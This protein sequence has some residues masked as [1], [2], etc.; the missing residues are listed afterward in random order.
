VCEP[1]HVSFAPY[2]ELDVELMFYLKNRHGHVSWERVACGMGL[3]NIY[4]FLRSRDEQ[5]EPVWLNERFK[6]ED[7]AKVI[8]ECALEKKDVLCVQAL[9]LMV[10]YVA[11]HAANIALMFVA[12]G[13]V[14]IGGGIAPKI[15]SK[16]KEPRFLEDFQNKGR[17]TPLLADMPLKVI[18]NPDTALLGA[19]LCGAVLVQKN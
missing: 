13:G 5:P 19:A 14:Y 1:G 2:T 15:L 7:A 12:S 6:K 9:D 17:M 8:S 3:V 16:L 10:R 18:L 11:S 4:E